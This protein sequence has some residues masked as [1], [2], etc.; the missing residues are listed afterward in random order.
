MIAEADLKQNGRVD[1]EEFLAL[2]GQKRNKEV[3]DMK[4]TLPTAVKPEEWLV[5][6]MRWISQKSWAKDV[7][8]RR[9]QARWKNTEVK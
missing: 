5:K 8:M 2:M 9:T 4:E 7:I 1:L 6:G 3:G